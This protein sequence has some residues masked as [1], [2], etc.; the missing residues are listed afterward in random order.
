MGLCFSRAVISEAVCETL[1]CLFLPMKSLVTFSAILFKVY[2]RIYKKFFALG[3]CSY[4]G[5]VRANFSLLPLQFS[6][7]GFLQ[8][9]NSDFYCLA[10]CCKYLLKM[11]ERSFCILC[12]EVCVVPKVF[13]VKQYTSKKN[14]CVNYILIPVISIHLN[15]QG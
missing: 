6:V 1:I 7:A 15:L 12:E 8:R 11:E 5:N 4:Q 10:S 14:C 9:E 3:V 2:M 13:Q